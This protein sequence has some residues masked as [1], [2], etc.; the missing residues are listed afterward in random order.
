[1]RATSFI[2]SFLY[3]ASG[4]SSLHSDPAPP[5][6]WDSV[7]CKLVRKDSWYDS[8]DAAPKPPEEKAA[9]AR[10]KIKLY[11]QLIEL[12]PKEP[13]RCAE[14]RIKLAELYEELGDRFR[15]LYHWGRIW[16]DYPEDKFPAYSQVRKQAAD[17]ALKI[18]GNEE[19]PFERA[20]WNERWLKTSSKEAPAGEVAKRLLKLAEAKTNLLK[21]AVA[22]KFF[23]LAEEKA[24]GDKSLS[25]E[26]LFAK[27]WAL[28]LDGQTAQATRIVSDLM[29][30]TRDWSPEW[31]QARTVLNALGTAQGSRAIPPES[32]EHSDRFQ[33]AHRLTESGRNDRALKEFLRVIEDYPHATDRKDYRHLQGL[34]RATLDRIRNLPETFK[35]DYHRWVSSRMRRVL[36][37]AH[38]DRDIVPLARAIRYFG[39]DE[40]ADPIRKALASLLLE[41]GRTTI[42]RDAW[43]PLSKLL[44]NTATLQPSNTPNLP[45]ALRISGDRHRHEWAHSRGRASQSRRRTYF[46]SHAGPINR[47]YALLS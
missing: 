39:E 37:I 32:L 16:S 2:F 33:E 44:P 23:N 22:L 4:L 26:I 9:S 36:R 13:A 31:Y 40:G 20:F 41:Q 25:A 24:K 12:H 45:T 10:F 11:T 34:T 21:T 27:A 18:L 7:E 38:Q 8:E 17:T 19:S 47:G 5:D 1:L 3:L 46:L 43:P 30:T 29:G 35:E 14:G 15:A 42:A 6:W 28:N